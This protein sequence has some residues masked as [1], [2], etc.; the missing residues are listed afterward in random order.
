MNLNFNKL[1]L[2]KDEDKKIGFCFKFCKFKKESD[3]SN[4]SNIN[5]FFRRMV[6]ASNDIFLNKDNYFVLNKSQQLIEEANKILKE[7]TITKVYDMFKGNNAF[8]VYGFFEKNIFY[9]LEFD[10]NHSSR[11]E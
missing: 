11:P 2:I 9:V 4:K 10:L 5:K 8:R 6:V 3:Y 1:S 7:K